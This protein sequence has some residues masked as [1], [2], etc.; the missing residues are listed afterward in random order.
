VRV[1]LASSGSGS[2][3]GG[4]IFLDYLGRGLAARGHEVITW[5]PGH[6]RMDEL[7]ARCASFGRVVRSPY[8][9]TYDYHGRSLTASLN[10][11]ASRDAAR[12]WM[13]LRPDVVHLNKQ[14]LEDGL[15]LVRAL[16]ASD[17]GRVCTIHLT[18]TAVYLGAKA[19][20]LRDWLARRS[21]ARFPGVLVA[22]QPARE[23]SLKSFLP[24]GA[25]TATIF[26]GAPPLRAASRDE[27]RA[28]VR[29]E[30][31][32]GANDLLVLGVGRLVAQKNPRRFVEIARA[33][34]GRFPG[35]RFLWVGDGDLAGEW[36]AWVAQAGLEGAVQCVGWR[37][38]VAPF[39]LAADLLLHVAEFEGLPLAL[40]EAMAAGIP[41]AVTRGLVSEVP[42]LEGH[43]LP[44]DDVD[45]LCAA[46]ADPAALSA[47][48]A[49][50]RELADTRFSIDA[51][52][53]GY[54]NLYRDACGS[55]HPSL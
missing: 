35:A 3:G 9:N 42:P 34:R 10:R 33:V 14:N 48:A 30:H 23:A 24:P 29:A 28:R 50:A 18:Q 44:A 8:R 41:C 13:A 12:E 27:V 54:E 53:A 1:L 15:D 37:P 38:D 6:A 46:L 32:I 36:R 17:V 40:V 11:R 2:R 25:R 39:L 21:L 43:V 45:A 49:G 7:A 52:A 47:I 5:M 4:E 20:A 16:G 22:V 55:R 31:G 51:M 26:N 19:A